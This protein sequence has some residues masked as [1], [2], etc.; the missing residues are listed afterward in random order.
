MVYAL[1]DSI[2]KHQPDLMKSTII[3][4]DATPA[5]D[6]EMK[7]F[8]SPYPVTLLRRRINGGFSKNVNMG[9]EFLKRHG[10]DYAF[11]LNN[12]L[13]LTQPITAICSY[14]KHV[15]SLAMVGIRLWYPDGR[16]QHGGIEIEPSKHLH[17][18]HYGQ[19]DLG[20][21]TRFVPIVT[22]AF[23]LLDIRKVGM[24]PEEYPLGY[25]DVALCLRTWAKGHRVLYSN[26]VSAI[27]AESQTRGYVVDK[28][29]FESLNVFH[30]EEFQFPEVGHQIQL[31][32]ECYPREQLELLCPPQPHPP[33][34]R[35]SQRRDRPDSPAKNRR[36]KW[37]QA[38]ARL[39]RE[40]AALA[41]TS[42]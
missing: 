15:E 6:E 17:H 37:A 30:R 25:E 16:L 4:D 8:F 34:V 28:R 10:V 38:Q 14:F 1:L 7:Y 21:P 13:I 11:L 12:D 40:R 32:Q 24:Y 26:S 31:A 9:L 22:G 20:A 36:E 29:Q 42:K 39:K 3:L 33:Y 27:H 18:L 2:Q 19:W 23:Q 35:D 5:T 41:S